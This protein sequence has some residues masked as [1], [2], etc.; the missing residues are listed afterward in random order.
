[1]R[2]VA[3]DPNVYD[4]LDRLSQMPHGQQTIRDMIKGPGGEKMVDY[5]TKSPGGAAS[6]GCSPRRPTATIQRSHKQ[7]L[8]VDAL[9]ADCSK[10]GRRH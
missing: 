8:T 3:A 6:A 5:M 2:R 1:M 7:H 9:L 4:R 10:A